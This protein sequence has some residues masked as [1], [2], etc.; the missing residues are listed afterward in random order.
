[1][2]GRIVIC[3]LIGWFYTNNLWAQ[4]YNADSLITLLV[5]DISRDQVKE[6]GEFYPGMFVSFRGAS[7]FP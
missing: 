4:A 3:I 5:N 2:I 7:A 1:M 6:R